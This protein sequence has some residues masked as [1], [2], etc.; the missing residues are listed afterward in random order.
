MGAHCWDAL[1]AWTPNLKAELDCSK[2]PPK[3][4]MEKEK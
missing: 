2:P 1:V 4:S 3:I